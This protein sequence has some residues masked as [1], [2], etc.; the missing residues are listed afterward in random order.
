MAKETEKMKKW[1]KVG[2]AAAFLLAGCMN[3]TGTPAPVMPKSPAQSV[4]EI[5]A[6]EAVAL[7]VFLRYKALPRCG[8]VGSTMLCSDAGVVSRVQAADLVAAKSIDTAEFAVRSPGF[9]PAAMQSL[10]Q[11]A[12]SAVGNLAGQT[13]S[14]KVN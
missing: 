4:F 5:K 8:Q 14:L 3:G 13:A 7:T 9:S 10:L 6:A 1:R 2:L 11:A 12:Q